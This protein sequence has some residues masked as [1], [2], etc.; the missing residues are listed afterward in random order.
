M[1]LF[2]KILIF[3]GAAG[4][5]WVL[6]GWNTSS[7]LDLANEMSFDLSGV[8]DLTVSY[9]EEN[10]Q[11]FESP[12]NTFVVKEYMTANKR[13]YY[14]KAEQNG[15]FIHISEGK[16]PFVKRGFSRRVEIYLPVGYHKNLTLTTTSGSIVSNSEKFVLSHIRI[17]ST[18]GSVSVQCMNAEELYF[19]TTSSDLDLGQLTAGQIRLETTS[20]NMQC[21][22]LNGHVSYTSTSGSIEV[23]S[24]KG[25][26]DYRTNQSGILKAVYAEV[27]GNLSFFNKNGDIDFTLPEELA[28]AFEATTKNGTAVTSFDKNLTQKEHTLKGIVGAMPTVLVKA[29]TR[30]GN[31]RVNQGETTQE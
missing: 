1:S 27:D 18:S 29:E 15:Q 16:K 7:A 17:A 20:G 14:A 26:G 21:L 13:R 9:D 10:I 2:K 23:R 31:I 28:F 6:S 25:S 8:S 5:L 30:N 3:L 4:I 22:A 19:S 12:G 24:A 11:L